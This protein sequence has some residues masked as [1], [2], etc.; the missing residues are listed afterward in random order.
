[1][2]RSLLNLSLVLLLAGLLLGCDSDSNSDSDGDSFDGLWLYDA[3]EDEEEDVFYVNFQGN[4]VTLYDFLGDEFDDGPDCYLIQSFTIEHIDG[5]RYEI[6]D[7]DGESLE[8]TVRRSGN[9]LSIAFS[10]FDSG[11][12]TRSNQNVSGLTPEC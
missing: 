2:Q 4:A 5:N 3:S 11:N 7:E 9:E 10:N 1:M 12:Y 8:V 6:T